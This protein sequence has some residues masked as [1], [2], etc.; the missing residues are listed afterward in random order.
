MP[1]SAA[2]QRHRLPAHE[3]L[4]ELVLA[5]PADN[6][7][8]QRKGEAAQ[9]DE[10]EGHDRGRDRDHDSRREVRA[11]AAALLAGGPLGLTRAGAAALRHG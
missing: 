6:D 7:H 5:H 1:A 2:N 3:H 11:A 8:E 4:V 9:V 10:D